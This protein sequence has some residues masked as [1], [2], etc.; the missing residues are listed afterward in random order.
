MPNIK[1]VA[2]KAN[3]SVATVSRVINHKGYVNIET[4]LL[5]EK[6]IKELKYI[7]N[8]FARSLF[9]KISKTI[10]VIFPHLSN[11][12]YY[13]V[14]EGIE[15]F[16]FENGY[17]VMICNS[18]EDEEREEEYLNQFVKYN[19][20]GIIIGSNSNILSR[21]KELNIPIVS[22]DRII[23]EEIPSVSSDN[24]GGGYVAA[25]KL[26]ENGCKNIIHFRGPSI[27]LTVQ[28]RTIGFNK[29]LDENNLTCDIVDLAFIDPESKLI[30]VCLENNP[31]IDGIF[32]DS[33]TIAAIVL[34]ELNHMGKKVPDDVQ[35][36]GYD[37]IILSQ[38][39]IPKLSTVSQKMFEIGKEAMISLHTLMENGTLDDKHKLIPV[40][41]IE[42]ESTKS[43]NL[44][45]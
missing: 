3:V 28:D 31:N 41:L 4:R 29:C 7:P 26:V 44:T 38:L 27:L 33:D 45:K 25:K 6:A 22:I 37:N 13:N 40:E 43:N 23:D 24:V 36:V 19:I 14:L 16:A 30:R 39:I 1:D 12:F 32:C 5:V 10:G 34:S 42:R 2:K 21:Y 18:N 15:E 17:K 9:K 20:D 8:E 35:V 11:S